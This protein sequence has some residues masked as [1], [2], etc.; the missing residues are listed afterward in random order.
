MATLARSL[1]AEGFRSICIETSPDGRVSITIGEVESKANLTPLE[2]WK[3]DRGA[4]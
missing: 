3:A 1:R 4:A 2:Q